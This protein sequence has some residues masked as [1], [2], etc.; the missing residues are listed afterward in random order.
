M[1][2]P[3]S[4]T[5]DEGLIT[6]LDKVLKENS[7][8]LLAG[9]LDS[10]GKEVTKVSTAEMKRRFGFL[11]FSENASFLNAKSLKKNAI[12]NFEIIYDLPIC[13]IIAPV[14][15]TGQYFIGIWRRTIDIPC[16]MVYGIELRGHP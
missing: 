11:D 8:F 3:I 14:R 5:I 13:V 4:A 2:R 7:Q 10:E 16:H 6:W 9:I 1:K 15:E 12:G